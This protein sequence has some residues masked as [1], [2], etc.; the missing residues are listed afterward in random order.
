MKGFN[1]TQNIGRLVTPKV[2]HN[3]RRSY[4]RHRNDDLKTSFKVLEKENWKLIERIGHK[5]KGSAETFGFE[6]LTMVGTLLERGARAQNRN[7]VQIV[8]AQFEAELANLMD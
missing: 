4:L 1:T 5:M 7:E 6:R 3:A 8:L 2:S